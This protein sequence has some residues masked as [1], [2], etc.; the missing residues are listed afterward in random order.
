VGWLQPGGKADYLLHCRRT[1][2]SWAD[3][4]PQ[5]APRRGIVDNDK[6]RGC[7]RA[8]ACDSEPQE[9][10]ACPPQLP[11]E[12]PPTNF[13]QFEVWLVPDTTRLYRV[14]TFSAFDWRPIDPPSPQLHPVVI[15]M[16]VKNHFRSGWL[17]RHYE[18]HV[19]PAPRLEQ[20][21]KSAAPK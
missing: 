2:S 4:R 7:V 14:R 8:V 9:R 20:R 5:S 19:N 1:P 18:T 16:Q 10:S 12:A 15:R 6:A 21:L 17:L 13:T 11:S 3:N